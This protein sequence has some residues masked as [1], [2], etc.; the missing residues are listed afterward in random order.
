MFVG[1]IPKYTGAYSVLPVFLIEFNCRTGARDILRQMEFIHNCMTGPF[2][3]HE[4]LSSS[5]SSGSDQIINSNQ[6][7]GS[8]TRRSQDSH[9]HLTAMFGNPVYLR[10]WAA[11]ST[12]I[13]GSWQIDT[14]EGNQLILT[15]DS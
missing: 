15:A 12:L 11:T 1:D 8:W 4:F 10:W 5:G 3:C 14:A 2:C 7:P 13:P 6:D 9:V